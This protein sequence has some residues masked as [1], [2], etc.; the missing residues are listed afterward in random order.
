[1]NHRSFREEKEATQVFKAH[2]VHHIGLINETNKRLQ[3]DLCELEAELA[4]TQKRLSEEIN[5]RDT[6]EAAYAVKL[7]VEHAM[8]KTEREHVLQQIHNTASD[9]D[10]KMIVV[11]RRL[12][13]HIQT[14]IANQVLS[15][16]RVMQIDKVVNAMGFSKYGGMW[17]DKK[18]EYTGKK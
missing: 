14:T 2:V 4:H 18:K 9:I 13:E 8:E 6:S 17:D 12:E 5:R 11:V 10:S 16:Y 15:D 1:M 3:C 7:I